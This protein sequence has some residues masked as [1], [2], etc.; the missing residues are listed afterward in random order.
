MCRFP[1]PHEENSLKRSLE[2]EDLGSI[3]PDVYA[4]CD[5]FQLPGMRVLQ[6]AFDGK[7]DNPHLP[8][9]YLGNTVV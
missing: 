9:T 4:L 5:Q 8:D 1:F 3:T 7:S 2:R 6:F